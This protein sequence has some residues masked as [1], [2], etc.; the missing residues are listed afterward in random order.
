MKFYFF[1]TGFDVK[2]E[3][4]NNM[5]EDRA[6]EAIVILDRLPKTETPE[7]KQAKFWIDPVTKKFE[8]KYIDIE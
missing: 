1:G 6:K 3:M 7:G 2:M 5:P 8:Y 4:R